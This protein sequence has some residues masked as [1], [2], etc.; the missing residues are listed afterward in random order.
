MNHRLLSQE[1]S[2]IDP[3]FHGKRF[4]FCVPLNWIEVHFLLLN[5]FSKGFENIQV[6]NDFF[7]ESEKK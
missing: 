6:L 1:F 4:F 3:D 2:P 7:R 5:R